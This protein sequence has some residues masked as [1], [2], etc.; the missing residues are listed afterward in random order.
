MVATGAGGPPPNGAGTQHIVGGS[1]EVGSRGTSGGFLT[2][3]AA[4]VG[5]VYVAWASGDHEQQT[6]LTAEVTGT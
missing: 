2:G 1:S 6:S 3:S 4:G 5:V